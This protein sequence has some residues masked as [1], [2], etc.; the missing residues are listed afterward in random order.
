VSLDAEI[1]RSNLAAKVRLIL[2]GDLVGHIFHGNQYGEGESKFERLLPVTVTGVDEDSPRPV[3][4]VAQWVSHFYAAG[5]EIVREPSASDTKG[6]SDFDKEQISKLE[7]IYEVGNKERE[8]LRPGSLKMRQLTKALVDIGKVE[9]I[10]KR[11]GTKFIAFDK[12]KNPVAAISYHAYKSHIAIGYIHSL[13]AV[14][15]AGA[16]LE[17][18][19]AKVAAKLKVPVESMALPEAVGFHL[20][21][22]RYLSVTDWDIDPEEREDPYMYDVDDEGILRGD[23]PLDGESAGTGL[24]D[25]IQS[26]W[27]AENCAQ[28]AQIGISTEPA[29]S[30]SAPADIHPHDDVDPFW[31]TETG[32]RILGATR[33][34]KGDLDGHDFHGNQHTGGIDGGG[35]DSNSGGEAS[36]SDPSRNQVSADRYKVS[37]GS[38]ETPASP[39]KFIG[40]SAADFTRAGGTVKSVKTAEFHKLQSEL[41]QQAAKNGVNLNAK[42]PDP[43][44]DPE[45]YNT[46]QGYRMMNLALDPQQVRQCQDNY[47]GDVRIL[48]ARDSGGTLAGA[49]M[50]QN[51]GYIHYIGSTH[52]SDGAGTALL[53]QVVSHASEAGKGVAFEPL[54]S[55]VKFWET[56]GF[57]PKTEGSDTYVM[58]SAEAKQVAEELKGMKVQKGDLNGHDFHGNQWTEGA[59]S[60]KVAEI[61]SRLAKAADKLTNKAFAAEAERPDRLED[62]LTQLKDHGYNSLDEYQKASAQAIKDYVAKG[63]IV[64]SVMTPEKNLLAILNS[65]EIQN[66][67]VSGNSQRSYAEKLGT[68]KDQRRTMENVAFGLTNKSPLSERPVYGFIDKPGL[69]DDPTVYGNA[70]IILNPNIKERSTVTIGDSLDT[71]LGGWTAR[72]A[73]TTAPLLASD[74]NPKDIFYPSNVRDIPNQLDGVFAHYKDTTPYMEAQIH[75]GLKTSDIAR[76][77]FYKEPSPELIKALDA[78]GIPH[79]I[80]KS[81]VTKGDLPGHTFHGNQWEM[82]AGGTTPDGRSYSDLEKQAEPVAKL[83]GFPDSRT[84][85]RNLVRLCADSTTLT[86][87]QGIT[88]SGYKSLKVANLIFDR[89]GNNHPPTVVS[90]DEFKAYRSN[91]PTLYTGIS[92]HRS[93][94]E[95]KI[96]D[97]AH[98][99]GIK[100]GSGAYGRAW[101]MATKKNDAATYASDT[102]N[103]GVKDGGLMT[104]KLKTGARVEDYDKALDGMEASMANYDAIP[105]LAE[106]LS[107]GKPELDDVAQ[108]LAQTICTGDENLRLAMNGVD[109]LTYPIE[110]GQLYVMVLNRGALVMSDHYERV[111]PDGL[112]PAP[113]PKQPGAVIK[114]DSP[115]HP[116][117]GNQYENGWGTGEGADIANTTERVLHGIQDDYETLFGPQDPRPFAGMGLSR[118]AMHNEIVRTQY[119]PMAKAYAASNVADAMAPK[120][121]AD[122]M[123]NQI[124]CG[125]VS[126]SQSQADGTASAYYLKSDDKWVITSDNKPFLI[127]GDREGRH[128]DTPFGETDDPTLH[129]EVLHGDDPRVLKCL[130][131]NGASRLVSLWAATSNGEVPGESQTNA[132]TLQ[133]AARDEFGIKDAKSWAGDNT[134]EVKDNY[135]AMGNLYRTF[136]RAQYD[137]TQR[138]FRDRGITEVPL[139]RGYSFDEPGDVPAWAKPSLEKMDSTTEGGAMRLRPMSAFA[140]TED[141]ATRF[142]RDYADG[143]YR[144]VTE[145]TVPVGRILS[146]AMTGFGCLHENEMVVLGGPLKADYVTNLSRVALNGDD[147]KKGDLMGHEFHGNQHTAAEHEALAEQASREALQHERRAAELEERGKNSRAVM[148]ALQGVQARM[149]ERQHRAAA[150]TTVA[151]AAP[152]WTELLDKEKEARGGGDE[153]GADII[154]YRLISALYDEQ[155]VAKGSEPGHPFH[156]NQW[157]D[158]MTDGR[159]GDGTEEREQREALDENLRHIAPEQERGNRFRA[160]RYK[161]AAGWHFLRLMGERN[162]TRKSETNTTGTTGSRVEP[163]DNEDWLRHL[164]WDMYRAGEPVTELP[165][166]LWALGVEGGTVTE[167]LDAMER[168]TRLPSWR[169]APETLKAQVARFLRD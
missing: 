50:V 44:K 121:D 14:K 140:Y 67:Y 52:E 101:Y 89:I 45:A 17:L 147:V 116:F 152:K 22:G 92:T 23:G 157:T 33:I 64:V 84:F 19:V 141:V 46:W 94:A 28:L 99:E 103:N 95:D 117:R 16:A 129:G 86:R 27:T 153:D 98:G 31:R 113:I 137:T 87:Y 118:E 156:G 167:Q 120:L 11:P 15:G 114:G 81:A 69:Q 107:A 61:Q 139:Y 57:K 105:A 111:G 39:S 142:A 123:M 73:D 127:N 36:Q 83:L 29:V 56:A 80:A 3:R 122:P 168:F 4:N 34:A 63:D 59:G 71:S 1:R 21:I 79:G 106:M 119:A 25:E 144:I 131:E 47:E 96:A 72:F 138:Y 35:S 126:G 104:L 51:G 85:V 134:N 90:P 58:R 150:E 78:N 100:I 8:K 148:S 145:S 32:M 18:E 65:G 135:R 24:V 26:T 2:K 151:K 162:E 12:D 165:D 136:L 110:R 42:S 55:A 130:R 49:A 9:D 108:A 132:L 66:G 60:E 166:L 163:M 5:G 125:L 112:T 154:H 97:F 41:E 160:D 48:V 62:R 158:G 75:G 13:R 143:D 159:D 102:Y 43:D 37:D 77:D 70:K 68:S 54:E 124:F 6:I 7:K 133:R 10:I 53:A 149:R 20:G 115:G 128:A 93:P 88:E 146:C 38:S 164:G 30:K 109:A 40:Q 155:G 76:V 161:L 74:P 91:L 169:A 82:G